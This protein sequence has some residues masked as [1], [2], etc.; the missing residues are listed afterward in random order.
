MQVLVID[1]APSIDA[2]ILQFLRARGYVVTFSRSPLEAFEV[3]QHSEFDCILLDLTTCSECLGLLEMRKL[4][5]TSAVTFMT[6][7]PIDVLVAEAEQE[8]SVEFQSLPDLIK[9]LEH[10][11]QPVML[12]GPNLPSPLLRAVRDKLLRVLIART[13]HFAMNLMVD[14]WCQIV[15]LP[16]EIPEL[17]RDEKIAIV[18]QINAKL[19]AILAS[20]LP[21]TAPGITVSPK[22]TTAIEFI[23]LLR[24]ISGDRL[25]PCGRSRSA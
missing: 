13:L 19:L 15:W 20:A 23:T 8:G 24:R 18:H 1:A 21:D 5:R 17:A 6:P 11:S 12:V 7:P 25:A 16:A 22:P 10:F 9:N 2:S 4:V 3:L 14:G